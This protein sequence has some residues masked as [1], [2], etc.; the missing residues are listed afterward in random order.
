M[1]DRHGA[2]SPT[3]LDQPA[4]RLLAQAS[5][6]VA[7]EAAVARALDALWRDE[8][9]STFMARFERL[10]LVPRPGSPV[11]PLSRRG[12]VGAVSSAGALVIS[13]TAVGSVLPQDA[14]F[15]LIGAGFAA[16]VGCAS[17]AAASLFRYADRGGR[18]DPALRV[19]LASARA[20]R[21]IQQAPAVLTGLDA[22]DVAIDLA[23]QMAT[24]ADAAITDLGDLRARDPL[25]RPGSMRRTGHHDRLL[26]L[27]AEAT[28][29][30]DL[31]TE[32]RHL[33]D[34]AAATSPAPSAEEVTAYMRKEID[35]VRGVL[36]SAPEPPTP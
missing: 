14:S 33:V 24:R 32:R 34:Q 22:P 23:A 25:V 5:E 13:S 26:R 29:L 15:T 12:V 20:Y 28:V 36:D 8:P 27:A 2:S 19:P 10:T 1:S 11:A 7:H 6:P 17:W 4:D 31:A 21:F 18:C 9:T 16:A 3:A 35:T 30:I